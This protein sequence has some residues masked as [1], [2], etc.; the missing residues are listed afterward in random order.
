VSSNRHDEQPGELP[1]FTLTGPLRAAADE[2]LRYQLI[3]AFREFPELGGRNV[4]V[5]LTSM[6]GVD[7]LAVP[8]EMV[9]RLNATRRRVSYFTIGHELTHLLQRPGL[10]VIPSGEVQCDIWTLARSDLFLDDR[11]TYL[12]VA[13]SAREWPRHAP[14]VRRL[15]REALAVRRRDRRYI[16]WL[17]QQLRA[18]FE[19]PIALPLFDS[20]ATELT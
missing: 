5:G 14:V 2:G 16:V 17:A 4:T 10:G 9:I 8:G 3:R 6:R 19:R 15:C 13:C 11:P 7:G 12:K 20:L 18:Y 1:A